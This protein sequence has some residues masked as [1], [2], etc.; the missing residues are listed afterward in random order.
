[1][2]N[3]ATCNRSEMTKAY[4][5]LIKINKALKAKLE[6]YEGAPQ[7]NEEDENEFQ[8]FWAAYGRKGNIKSTRKRWFNL[9]KTKR[10][11]AMDKV[12]AYVKST[13]EKCYRKGGEVWLLNECWNDEIVEAA[14][15]FGRPA[16][17]R[18]MTSIVEDNQEEDKRIAEAAILRRTS[19]AKG[20]NVRD[21]IK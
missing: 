18:A 21:M 2:I 16:P 4:Q 11:L 14:Q 6:V 7:T 9:P 10:A 13:P 17:V 3:L 15:P 1:M 5:E 19:R 8:K 12:A 20:R